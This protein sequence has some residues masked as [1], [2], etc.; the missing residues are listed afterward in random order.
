MTLYS[1]YFRF[2][3]ALSV[4]GASCFALAVQAQDRPPKLGE[5]PPPREVRYCTNCA[6]VEALKPPTGGAKQY[7]MTIRYS[8]GRVKTFRY[9][10][11]PGLRVGEKVK[12]NNGVVVRDEAGK[13]SP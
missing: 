9:D 5:T 1:Q 4:I 12:D 8:D 10:N 7:E 6:T 3:Q 11:D 2:I 13:P